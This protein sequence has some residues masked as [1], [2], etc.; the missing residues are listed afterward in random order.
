MLLLF[1]G[2][3]QLPR[4]AR[5]TGI[6]ISSRQDNKET[7]RGRSALQVVEFDGRH[8]KSSCFRPSESS[9][10]AAA[11]TTRRRRYSIQFNRR[12]G[13]PIR[14][15]IIQNL[16][17]CIR[18]ESNSDVCIPNRRIRRSEHQIQELNGV[19]SKSTIPRSDLQMSVSVGLQSKS[20]YLMVRTITKSDVLYLFDSP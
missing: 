17:V 9:P 7:S 14:P 8:F 11:T 2:Q 10:A 13:Q 5:H 12:I 6:F 3:R 15:Q 19:Q 4:G 20:S 18:K 1:H 16:R